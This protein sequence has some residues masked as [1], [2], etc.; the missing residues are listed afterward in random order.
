MK[1]IANVDALFETKRI[2]WQTSFLPL[3]V[4]RNFDDSFF[5]IRQSFEVTRNI[6]GLE[7]ACKIPQN[8]I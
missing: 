3:T 2:S 6:A 4:P 5:S 1:G 8:K 7:A